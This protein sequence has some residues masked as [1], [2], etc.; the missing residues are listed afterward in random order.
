MVDPGESVRRIQDGDWDTATD[1]PPDLC[2]PETAEWLET[3][4]TEVKHRGELK[5]QHTEPLACGRLLQATV[6]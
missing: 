5:H 1:R 4:S 3:C 2:D 6:Y